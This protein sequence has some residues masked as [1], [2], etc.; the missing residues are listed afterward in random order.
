MTLADR[1]AAEHAG[2]EIGRSNDHDRTACITCDAWVEPQCRCGGDRCEEYPDA[3]ERPSLARIEVLYTA[4]VARSARLA[5]ALRG[6]S[7]GGGAGIGLAAA[8]ALLVTVW[9]RCSDLGP[10]PQVLP[11]VLDA[12]ARAR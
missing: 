10:V 3:P 12:G 6:L 9:A 11:V 7:L 1:I 5:T 4:P 2:H 8:L